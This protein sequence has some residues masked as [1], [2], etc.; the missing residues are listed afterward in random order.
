MILLLNEHF[1]R[2]GKGFTNEELK[3]IPK[4]SHRVT[5][6]IIYPIAIIYRDPYS[7]VYTD[8][9]LSYRKNTNP[10]GYCPYLTQNTLENMLSSAKDYLIGNKYSKEMYKRSVETWKKKKK[11]KS[12]VKPEK[13][14][15]CYPIAKNTHFVTLLDSVLGI[16]YYQMIYRRKKKKEVKV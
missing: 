13:Q 8:K 9:P 3:K 6:F 12:K 7:F 15:S 4:G 5:D 14:G 10:L 1:D 2:R 16:F 11:K